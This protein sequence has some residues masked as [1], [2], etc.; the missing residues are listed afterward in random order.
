MTATETYNAS[1]SPDKWAALAQKKLEER[2]RMDELRAIRRE[3]TAA[4]TKAFEYLFM[5]AF[6]IVFT[7]IAAS[8]YKIANQKLVDVSVVNS[9]LSKADLQAFVNAVSVQHAP[10]EPVKPVVKERLTTAKPHKIKTRPLPKQK[11][12]PK[13]RWLYYDTETGKI[14]EK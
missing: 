9:G 6:F 3:R 4:Y 12:E 8:L 10:P 14:Y 2:L 1:Q 11:A 5:A 7:V 13:A